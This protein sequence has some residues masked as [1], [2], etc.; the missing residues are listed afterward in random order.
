[1]KKWIVTISAALSTLDL[2]W[3]DRIEKRPDSAKE[4]EMFGGKIRIRN[5]HKIPGIATFNFRQ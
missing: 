2:F 1:M 5:F 3:K 4:E